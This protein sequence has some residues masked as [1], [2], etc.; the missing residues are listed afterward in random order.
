MIESPTPLASSFR[1]PHGFVF[2][3][4]GTIYRQV[5]ENYRGDF[6]LLK[7]SGLYERLVERE[8]LI[9]HEEVEPSETFAEGA[10]RVLRPEQVP[11]VSYPHEW[12]FSQLRDA[13]LATLEIQRLAI[14]CGMTLK[15]ASAYNIQFVRGKPMLIDT[16]SLEARSDGA[17]WQAY[18]QFCQH[19]LG[20]LAISAGRDVRLSQLFRTYLDGIPLD[21]ASKLL[22]SSSYFRPSALV[23]VHLHARTQQ[24]YSSGRKKTGGLKMSRAGLLGMIASLESAVRKLRWNPA[25]TEW[26]DYY[27]GTNYDEPSLLHKEELVSEFLRATGAKTAWDL[28]A[29]TGRFSRLAVEQGVFTVSFDLDSAAVE[30]N[31]LQLREEQG[32]LLLPLLLDLT[33]PSP[34]MGWAHGE[35]MSLEDRGPV[36]VILGL[37]LIHHLVIS[38]NVPL[39][40]VAEFMAKLGEWLIFEFVPKSD[41]QVQKLFASRPDIF[42]QY[43]LDGFEAAFGRY[44]DIERRERVRGS[45]RVLFLM[46]RR[47]ETEG[48]QQ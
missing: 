22:P 11:F 26:V 1:D 44:F 47:G 32:E 17:P 15:D 10:Y 9:P 34:S 42:P 39:R 3:H 4:E 14:E 31:Y 45:E 38:N 36:D 12:C 27:D 40:A 19:F 20:P 41:S 6:E 30:K 24:K 28:G 13:A 33:N 18:R 8:L 21:L 35:R 5:N 29:N 43:T 25:G 37:A 2:A 16:L 7:S 23:H 46:R 48:T